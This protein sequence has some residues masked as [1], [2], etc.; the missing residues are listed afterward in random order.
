MRKKVSVIIPVYNEVDCVK[1]LA[2]QIMQVLDGGKYERELFFID[3]G[4]TDGTLSVLQLLVLKFPE[5]KWI[6]FSRNFGHQAALKAGIDH[7]SGDCVISMDGD[8]QHPP[9]LLPELLKKWEEGYDI[10]YTRRQEFPKKISLKKWSSILFYRIMNRLGN[11][12]LEDGVADFRLMDRKVYQILS[13]LE[14]VE[15]FYR[16]LVKWVG[17][18]SCA[19]NYTVGKR[20]AGQTKY[21]LHKMIRL[22]IN[23]ITSF[24]SRP[25][26]I[27]IYIGLF[28][29]FLAILYFFY[30]LWQ[31]GMGNTVSGWTSLVMIVVFF[32]GIQMLILGIIG[33]YISKIFRQTKKR[34]VY[35]IE[36]MNL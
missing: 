13:S 4:S 8:L 31:Y 23:G 29:A 21:S 20:Y 9:S 18:N 22:A 17:F 36:S 6:R 27:T 34:P 33:I 15:L 11:I 10:V 19:I 7:V 1:E 28:F 12:K 26:Y 32:G 16:G 25:L 24:S 30:A 3:D 14:E 35:I 2:I 5:I